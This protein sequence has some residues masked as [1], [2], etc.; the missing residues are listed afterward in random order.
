MYRGPDFLS[1]IGLVLPPSPVSSCLSFS[2]F[3][4]VAGQAFLGLGVG[5]GEGVEGAKSYDREKAWS[6]INH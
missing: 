6:S 2:V 5:R 4:L 1:V 3:L